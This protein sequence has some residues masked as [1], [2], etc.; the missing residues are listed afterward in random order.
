MTKQPMIKGYWVPLYYAISTH[1]F[2]SMTEKFPTV[3]TSYSIQK[4]TQINQILYTNNI[5]QRS[6]FN[7]LSDTLYFLAHKYNRVCL[8]WSVS[9]EQRHTQLSRPLG[10]V[11]S[12]WYWAMY[13]SNTWLHY[14]VTLFTIFF[15][16]EKFSEMNRSSSYLNTFA[17]QLINI[18]KK[19]RKNNKYTLISPS[20]ISIVLRKLM[21]K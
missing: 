21:L 10:D 1:C 2:G 17:N 6:H 18:N 4:E 15:V 16:V 5:L 19:M 12:T 8:Q 14:F 3:F 7:F 11:L 9:H 13:S 20:I